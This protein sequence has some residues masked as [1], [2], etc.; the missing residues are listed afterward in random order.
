MNEHQW[1]S[2][3][4]PAALLDSLA[5]QSAA[6]QRKLRLFACACVR[7]LQAITSPDRLRAIRLSE[8][9]ADGL[10]E[11][12]ALETALEQVRRLPEVIP[13]DADMALSVF[14][15]TDLIWEKSLAEVVLGLGIPLDAVAL[16]NRPADIAATSKVDS[17]AR[18]RGDEQR[19]Q[20]HLVRDIFG[21][22][23]RRMILD[24]PCLKPSTRALAESIYEE[25]RFADLPRLATMVKKDGACLHQEF[26]NHCQ[27]PFPHVR[28]CWAVD[29]VL[30]R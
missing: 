28:G 16:A 9:Y 19:Q 11:P 18:A 1:L 17:S 21:N 3:E 12:R 30:N 4:D 25:R 22:P 13:Y 27:E 29:L 24:H 2:C 8:L 26:G 23:F 5:D 6:R 14:G 7:R 15:P 10:T 20:A